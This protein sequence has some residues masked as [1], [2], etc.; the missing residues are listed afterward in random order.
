M[1]LY[2]TVLHCIALYWVSLPFQSINKLDQNDL[3]LLNKMQPTLCY[4]L[5][6]KFNMITVLYYTVL[7]YVI[8]HYII[9]YYIILYYTILYYTVLYYIILYYTTLY[10]TI[11]YYTA[12]YY[13]MLYYTIIY[14]TLLDCSILQICKP[15]VSFGAH[16]EVTVVSYMYWSSFYILQYRINFDILELV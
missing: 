8:L 13:A 6:L 16:W 4:P 11:L 12:L 3:I 10:Y 2:R 5:Q 15:T 7:Y 9:L 14:Y 1:M